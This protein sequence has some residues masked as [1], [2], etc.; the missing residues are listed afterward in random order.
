KPAEGLTLNASY[1]YTY[2]DIPLIPVTYAAAGVSTTV[3]QKFYIV[4]TPRNSASASA[5]YEMAL[6]GNGAAVKFHFDGNYSQS[7]QAFDQFPT[8]NDSSL[9]FN[10]R[11]AFADIKLSDAGQK[12][13]VAFWGRNVFDEQ[14]VF[15][16][17]PSNSLPAVQTT[18]V[19]VG[20]I[21]NTLGDYGNFNAPRTFG[22]E[23]TINF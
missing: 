12:L 2:T 16:R 11:V 20:S 7:T 4:F 8:H 13:T 23:A 3:D 6:G 5:D 18:N 15:R 1:A 21:S 22:V 10:A 9:I 17:D 14:H 19:Y